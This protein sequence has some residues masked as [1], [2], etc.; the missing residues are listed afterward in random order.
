[1]DEGAR[2]SDRGRRELFATM[3]R[4]EEMYGGIE[5]GADAGLPFIMKKGGDGTMRGGA[6][7]AAAIFERLRLQ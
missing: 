6:S 1:M 7:E 4:N 5:T 2:G 3:K